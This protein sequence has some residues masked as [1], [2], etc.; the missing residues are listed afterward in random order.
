MTATA[1][2]R[3][4]GRPS[5][6]REF[7]ASV[8]TIM[9]KELRSRMRGRRAFV[10]LTVYLGLLAAIAYGVYLMVAPLARDAAAGGFG[11][12]EFQA[13][14]VS[15][16]IGMAIFSVLSILQ[17][18]LVSVI[19]PAFT[20]GQISLEREKQTLDLLVTTPLRPGAIVIGKLATALAF[21]VLMILAAI[22]IT[23][24]VLMY[25]GA[26]VMD[27]V[28]QQAVL[29][30]TAI[31]FGSVGIFVSALMKRTQS[32][33]VVTYCAVIGAI[34]GSAMLFGFWQSLARFDDPLGVQPNGGAPEQIRFVNPMVA[35]LDV[36][37][38]VEPP[39]GTDLTQ[40]LYRLF[41]D[42]L[43]GGWAQ[44]DAPLDRDVPQAA[45]LIDTRSSGYWWPR[46][47]I[48]M[49]AVAVLLTLGA[50]RLVV[51]IGFRWRPRGRR[52]DSAAPIAEVEQP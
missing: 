31:G 9:V 12:A 2:Q 11:N 41:G 21:V 29:L 1:A 24:I 6:V 10:V 3:A 15:S 20:A 25:G 4:P 28:R 37:A 26:Q 5:A 42:D 14:N 38:N 18:V 51:P 49:L 27:I 48:T 30:A 7:L 40:P 17:I 8:S 16:L 34:L 52:E 19:A 13:A 32:A 22:P 35:M 33:T 50:M 23:A 43:S 47:S 46:V 39:G 36:V 45:P 44:V